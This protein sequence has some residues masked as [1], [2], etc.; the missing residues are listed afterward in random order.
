MVQQ[1]PRVQTRPSLDG[2]DHI[3]IEEAFDDLAFGPQ[4]DKRRIV[5]VYTIAR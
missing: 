1:T 5:H 3:R 2:L 4:R